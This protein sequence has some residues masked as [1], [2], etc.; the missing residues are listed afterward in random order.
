MADSRDEGWLEACCASLAEQLRAAQADNAFLA[1]ELAA[2]RAAATA[3][4]PNPA[5]D[6]AATS[7]SPQS[8]PRSMERS[9]GQSSPM[10]WL[11]EAGD[12]REGGGARDDE[13]RSEA[14]ALRMELAAAQAG[15]SQA[16]QEAAVCAHTSPLISLQ[17]PVVQRERCGWPR[18]SRA[19][20]KRSAMRRCTSLTLLWS[21]P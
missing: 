9:S 7:A 8:S 1:D 16:E 21:K 19:G 5:T 12:E 6:H 4:N 10:A 20:P 18:R 15:Q 13:L 11:G 3:P 2:A 17:H 14:D